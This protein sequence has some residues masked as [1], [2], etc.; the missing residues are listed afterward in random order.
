M[1]YL[2]IRSCDRSCDKFCDRSCDPHDFQLVIK[3]FIICNTQAIIKNNNI[4]IIKLE[5]LL[6]NK[7]STSLIHMTKV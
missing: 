1:L 7:Y 2:V 5:Y 6:I 3:Y 4:D